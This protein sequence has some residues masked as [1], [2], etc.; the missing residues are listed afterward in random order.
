MY[1]DIKIYIDYFLIVGRRYW[2]KAVCR[3]SDIEKD[4]V[5]KDEKEVLIVYDLENWFDKFVYK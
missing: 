4:K 2:Y 5:V 3:H 1:D